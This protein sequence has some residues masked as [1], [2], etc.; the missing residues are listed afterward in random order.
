M[1]KTLNIILTTVLF[2][3]SFHLFSQYKVFSGISDTQ[4]NY[5]D[6]KLE[7]FGFGKVTYYYNDVTKKNGIWELYPKVL[8]TDSIFAVRISTIKGLTNQYSFIVLYDSKL[9]FAIHSSL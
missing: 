5:I 4:F 3:C 8:I 1:T 9:E 2:L 6:A 7:Q